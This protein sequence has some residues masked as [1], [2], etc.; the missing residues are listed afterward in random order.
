LSAIADIFA[1]VRLNLETGTFEVDAAKVAGSVGDSMSTKLN[2]NL[3]SALGA[4]I[5][6]LAGA[7]LAGAISGA[8]RLNELAGEYQV[9]TGANV[10]EAKAFSGVLNDLFKNAHQGYDEIAQTLI[11][12]KTHFNLA[13]QEAKALAAGVLDFAEVAGGGGVAAVERLNSL[14]KTG[15][16]AQADMGVT[17]D[18]LVASRQL[19]GVDINATIDNLVKFAPAMNAAGISTDQALGLMN[20]FGKAGISADRATMG[21]SKALSKVKSPEELT[22]L[23]ADISNTEDPFVRAQKAADLFGVRAGAQL[24]NALRPGQG[25]IEAF[26]PTLDQYSNAVEKAGEANDSTFGGWALLQLHKFQG[27]LA[28]VAGGLGTS[29]D[30]ILMAAALLGPRLTMGILAG[31]GGIGGLLVPKIAGLFTSNVAPW[32]TTGTKIGTIMGTAIGPAMALAAAAAVVMVWDSINKELN[33]QAAANSGRLG[34]VIST[35]TMDQLTQDRAAIGKGIADIMSI[36]F[37]ETL[38]GDQLA[39]LRADLAKVDAAI[40]KSKEAL[41]RDSRAPAPGSAVAGPSSIDP[42]KMYADAA[43]IANQVGAII[44]ANVRIPAALVS[45]WFGTS[46]IDQVAAAAK[47]TGALG[48]VALAQGIS[49]A[50][51]VPV[52]AFNTM[53][54]MLKTPETK[55]QEEMR[56]AGG[57]TSKALADGLR[58][59]DPEIKAQ[60]V[61]VRRMLVARLEELALST[62]ALGASAM[63]ELNAGLASKDSTI[64]RTAELARD[65]VLAALEA[66]A[67]ARTIGAGIGSSYFEG[68]GSTWLPGRN[69]G[70]GPIKLASGMPYVEQTMPAIIHAG[71]AVLTVA[72][73]DAWRAG[74]GGP[75][76]QKINIEHVEIRDAH[77]EFSLI[78]QL[79]FLASVG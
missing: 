1:A 58:S 44:G 78:Q 37:G 2:S 55:S 28:D 31:L 15:V 68:L 53:L 75:R 77:D 30:A 38:Y 39:S 59:Q 16:I 4:G 42:A 27:A 25:G 48:M 40:A 72:Q 51:Q 13:G 46:T 70:V 64:R 74:G 33:S 26:I 8:T 71:E 17:M 47:R 57:L 76:E 21:F 35:Q 23:V 79:R 49:D 12:L 24:A 54:E 34:E 62:H 32:M 36:P 9:Q 20:L 69:A 18:K 3:K 52:D 14:V 22:R 6:A 43:R 67:K 65:A 56:L 10:A 50:R 41:W 45:Q 7:G 63:D 5:G 11:G 66:D 60:A 19:F 73:A 29:S 61:A